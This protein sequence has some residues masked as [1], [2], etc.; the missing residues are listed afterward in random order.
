MLKPAILYKEEITKGF[1]EYY[2]T[3]DRLF[4]YEED[5]QIHISNMNGENY[6]DIDFSLS[7]EVGSAGIFSESLTV[8]LLD[9][10]KSQGDIDFD[11]Y[12]ELYPESI[13]VFKPQLK[14][15]R[16]K[17]LEEQ[18][19]QLLLQQSMNN[20]ITQNDMLLGQEQQPQQM[21]EQPI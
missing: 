11:E 5:N 15:L 4:S 14:K 17:K 10:M 21:M 13:M 2:Y 18:Q 1:Q 20:P 3:D 12:I 9:N 19:Q 6:K 16:Q 7:V 8:S